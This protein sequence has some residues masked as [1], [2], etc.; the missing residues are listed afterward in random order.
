MGRNPAVWIRLK[1]LKHGGFK[2]GVI[3]ELSAS[4]RLHRDWLNPP[5]NHAEQGGDWLKEGPEHNCVFHGFHKRLWGN[6]I[7]FIQSCMWEKCLYAH[8]CFIGTVYIVVFVSRK[9]KFAGYYWTIINHWFRMSQKPSYIPALQDPASS[10]T[11]WLNQL[12]HLHLSRFSFGLDMHSL[13]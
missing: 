12:H 10:Q 1:I 9:L 6:F 3:R 4:P 5:V 11:R 13:D 7:Q 8:F 2:Q